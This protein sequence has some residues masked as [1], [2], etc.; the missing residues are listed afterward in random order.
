LT[1]DIA[2]HVLR[3]TQA[4]LQL[5]GMAA[6]I[7]ALQCSAAT[8]PQCIFKHVY[9]LLQHELVYA[10][11]AA[12]MHAACFFFMDLNC[13][14]AGGHVQPLTRKKPQPSAAASSLKPLECYVSS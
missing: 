11:A 2:C 14:D 3:S 12:C 4:D 1:A 8:R 5:A 6:A 13:A 9:G 7:M 10:S